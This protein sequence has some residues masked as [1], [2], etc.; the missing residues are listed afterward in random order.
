MWKCDSGHLRKSFVVDLLQLDQWLE[1]FGEN[2]HIVGNDVLSGRGQN[3]QLN[4]IALR[5][6]FRTVDLEN[7]RHGDLHPALA[8]HVT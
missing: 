5:D 4:Q 7:L 3:G 6:R 2:S 8:E 1:L